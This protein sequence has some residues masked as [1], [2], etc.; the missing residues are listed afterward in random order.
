MYTK[1]ECI[2]LFGEYLLNKEPPYKINLPRMVIAHILGGTYNPDLIDANW[3]EEEAYKDHPF[4]LVGIEDKTNSYLKEYD[5]WRC[6]LNLSQNNKAET[7]KECNNFKE[8]LDY[9]ANT[10]QPVVIGESHIDMTPN[11]ILMHNLELLEEKKA[12]IFIEGLFSEL[13]EELNKSIAQK[14]PTPLIEAFLINAKSHK[15]SPPYT[16]KNLIRACIQKGMP[17]IACDNQ[18]TILLGKDCNVS[19][20]EQTGTIS[21]MTLNFEF[22]KAQSYAQERYPDH[23]LYICKAG[24]AH[25]YNHW[26]TNNKDEGIHPGIVDLL[27]GLFVYVRDEKSHHK[28]K[29]D[30]FIGKDEYFRIIEE[31]FN[32]LNEE[33]KEELTNKLFGSCN[34]TPLSSLNEI[35][36]VTTQI[37]GLN[38]ENSSKILHSIF[39]T[40]SKYLQKTSSIEVT[41]LLIEGYR[42]EI[43]SGYQIWAKNVEEIIENEGPLTVIIEANKKQTNANN[44]V[45]YDGKFIEIYERSGF[46]NENLESMISTEQDKKNVNPVKNFNLD[47]EESSHGNQISA[48]FQN[49]IQLSFLLYTCCF[50]D[51]IS[52]PI[53]FFIPIIGQ[54][55]FGARL[56]NDFSPLTKGNFSFFGGCCP[57]QANNESEECPLDWNFAPID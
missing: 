6:T 36:K 21:R 44:H 33:Y 25:C 17:I 7:Q 28:F 11:A 34:F 16:S 38:M 1:K 14:K 46:E 9:A 53:A 22:Y 10:M 3:Y 29:R 24:G 47:K 30:L 56:A 40:Y 37:S 51:E 42:S 20:E 12:I 4:S 5:T 13:Q 2:E 15:S 32:T 52:L 57:S 19:G 55:Y 49:Q 43:K 54:L 39:Q 41:D 8:I 26:S 35:C 27:G 23:K 45:M 18:L 50:L 48:Q 31:N